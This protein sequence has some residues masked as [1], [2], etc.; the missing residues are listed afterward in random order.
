[1]AAAGELVEDLMCS[2]E[3]V[4]FAGV[5][6]LVTGLKNP[7]LIVTGCEAS[8]LIIFLGGSTSIVEDAESNDLLGLLGTE[9]FLDLLGM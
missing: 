3:K 6:V 2:F 4:F 5:L 9:A 8:I 7:L 1:M